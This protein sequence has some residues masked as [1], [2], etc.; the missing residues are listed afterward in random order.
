MD[1]KLLS[2]TYEMETGERLLGNDEHIFTESLYNVQNKIAKRTQSRTYSS[3]RISG[4]HHIKL[5]HYGHRG[6]RT[7][8]LC[9][10]TTWQMA[11]DAAGSKR[12]N[13]KQWGGRRWGECCSEARFRGD[14]SNKLQ[15][16]ITNYNRDSIPKQISHS[17]LNEMQYIYGEL[18]HGTLTFWST[19]TINTADTYLRPACH[20][21]VRWKMPLLQPREVVYCAWTWCY[22]EWKAFDASPRA[23]ES[24]G[25]HGLGDQVLC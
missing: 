4:T 22:S 18:V 21:P 3:S 8:I 20:R 25:D 5:Q 15:K 6:Q 11:I 16:G 13:A 24:R 23:E 9:L 1:F 17:S 19:L 14:E 10:A 2:E 12:R 7:H